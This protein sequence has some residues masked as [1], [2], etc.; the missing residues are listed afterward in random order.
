MAS[1]LTNLSSK[2]AATQTRALQRRHTPKDVND[3]SADTFKPKA[4]DYADGSFLKKFIGACVR[5]AINVI[6]RPADLREICV[7]SVCTGSAGDVVSIFDV[8]EAFRRENVNVEFHLNA[9][10]ELSK[11]KRTFGMGVFEA[12]AHTSSTTDG[13]SV[14][15]SDPCA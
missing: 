3:V 5:T 6:G 14:Q 2:T 15:F 9:T 7:V 12:C 4:S 8:E 13:E 11:G 10:C 1:W